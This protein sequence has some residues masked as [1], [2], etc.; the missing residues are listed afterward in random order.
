MKFKVFV[1][2]ALLTSL[3]ILNGC[4]CPC[5]DKTATCPMPE[6][7]ASAACTDATIQ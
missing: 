4:K 5:S 1:L 7:V 2:A 3:F 6:K